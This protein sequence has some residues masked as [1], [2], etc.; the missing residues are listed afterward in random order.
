M[1][2][3]IFDIIS[4]QTV[5]IK[6]VSW[7]TLEV[8]PIGLVTEVVDPNGNASGWVD[9]LGVYGRLGFE[10]LGV[11]RSGLGVSRG[12]MKRL[13]ERRWWRKVASFEEIITT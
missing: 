8:G 13:Y 7:L 2:V 11:G 10:E 5:G 1:T 4:Q 12:V 6:F 9:S 3:R